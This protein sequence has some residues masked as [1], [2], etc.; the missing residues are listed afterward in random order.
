MKSADNQEYTENEVS[1]KDESFLG[2]IEVV[3]AKENNLQGVDLSIP[4]DKLIVFTGLSGSGKSSLAF[5]TIYAEGQRRYMETFSAYAMQFIGN[6]KRPDVDK[7]SGLRPVIA[8]EQKSSNNNPRS[9]V[10][11]VTEIYDYL[12]LLYAR[13]SD[14]YSYTTGEKMIKYSESQLLIDIIEKFSQKKIIILSPV[15]K[16]RKGHYRELFEQFQRQGFLKVRIDGDI[17][18]IQPRMQLDRYKVHDIDIVV[19]TIFIDSTAEQRLANS[20]QTAM[21]Q[22]KGEFIVW[23]ID[24]KVQKYY[25]KFLMCPSTGV[26]Y[27]EP[28]P[29][30]FSFNSPYGACSRCNGLGSIYELDLNRIIPDKSK[31]IKRGGILPLADLEDSWIQKQIDVIAKKFKFDI[32]TPISE[33]PEEAMQIILYGS[34]EPLHIKNDEIGVSYTYNLSFEGIA[35]VLS[36]QFNESNSYSQK[37]RASSYMNHLICPECKGSRLKK[38]SLYFKI[39]DKNI[40]DLARMDILKLNNWLEALF[41]KIDKKKLLIGKEII[42]EIQKRIG[43]L[44]DVGLAYLCLNRDSRSLSGGEAQRIR[45]AT[46]VGS[47][48]T[49]VLYILD[50]PSIGLHPR[51][52]I[53]LINSLK[54]LRDIGN[55]VIVV[56]HDKEMIMQS[57]YVF[58]IGPGAGKNG[59]KIIAEG[60]PQEILK[61]N[62]LT[63][64]Y[65]N[66][67]LEI[68]IPDKLRKG[69]GKF[70][71]LIGASGNNLKKID[72]TFPLGV[73]ICV[74][75][76]SGSGKS[77]L[78]NRTLYPILSSYFY[79]SEI[80]PL[81]YTAIEGID[82]IDK[83]IKVDQSPIGRTPRSNPATYTG[84]FDDIRKLYA[85]L[86]ESKIRGYKPGRF[87]FNVKGGRC[88]MCKGAG[89]RT[90]EMNFLPDVYVKCESCNGKRYNRETLEVRYK[91][92]SINDVLDMDI[93][94]AIIFFENIPH[95]HHKI[96]N[97]HE[98]GLGYLSLGQQSTTLSGGEAQRIKLSTELLR[99]DS[100]NTLYILDEPTTGLHFDDIRVLLEVLKNLVDKGNTVII[101]EHNLDVI[102]VADYIIDM[103]PEGGE[104]GGYIIASGTPQEL[105]KDKK[106]YTAQYLKELIHK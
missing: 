103:G 25:S 7:I 100:G 72:T 31:S 26:S 52:N 30:S 66:G 96:I 27:N 53:R 41:G 46:Q 56:E 104:A 14:A 89:L 76:V 83:V 13:V 8:I 51:D 71:K 92:K 101:I 74:T 55:T 33:I 22:N 68:K 17:K 64:K 69:N 67:S 58:D 99:K 24:S 59:G 1:L 95:I 36:W 49:G 79:R 6:M 4:H 106:S 2:S 90:I 15:V 47:Q 91:G 44:L 94:Q 32:N 5:D 9:T 34:T 28:E 10:G 37:K 62:T 84:V 42:N 86:P 93:S 80:K 54:N 18:E 40:A 75:G 88:E 81:P 65:L 23:D 16:G 60:T 61:Q 102:K 39:D 87:S 3:N 82:N 97:L 50:E 63:S 12:R 20:V 43:F 70:L 98:I 11:T 45:L 105:I 73:M 85:E 57:D 78:V 29:N 77:S 19:D 48:L 35:N 21:K 38:E